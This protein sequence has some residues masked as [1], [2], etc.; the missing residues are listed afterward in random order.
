[1]IVRESKTLTPRPLP[2]GLAPAMMAMGA[3]DGVTG[4]LLLAEPLA[5][6]RLMGVSVLPT[7][8]VFVRFI[9]AFVAAVGASYFLPWLP[10]NRHPWVPAS[11]PDSGS[12]R[13]RLVAVIDTTTLVRLSVGIFVVAAVTSSALTLPWLMVAVADLAIAAAQIIVRGKVLARHK[14]TDPHLAS[15]GG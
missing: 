6:L 15:T 9:G 13:A 8:P 10:A 7:E 3:L 2:M 4:L 14:R 12:A 1:M 5:T 11:R